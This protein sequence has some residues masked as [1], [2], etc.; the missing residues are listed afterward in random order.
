MKVGFVGLG[1]LG[2]E[3]AEVISEHYSLT[4]Y[5]INKNIKSNI[6]ISRT[7][8]ECC[9]D[10]N[11]V[12][13]A[14]PTP[15]H[16]NYDGRY[17]TSHLKPKDF[18][19]SIVKSVIKKIDKLIKQNTLIVL[20][21]TVLPGTIRREIFTLVKRGRFIYN[22]YLI[23]QGTVKY[24]LK[25]PEMIIIGTEKGELSPEALVLKKFYKKIIKNN[26]RYEIGNWEEAES[27]KVFYN[28]FITLKICFVNM[29]Q[30]VAQ[31]NKN[32]NV[33]I[34]TN[35]LKN[36][37]MRIMSPK[38]MNAG[39]GDGGGCHPRD[40]IALR[41]LSKKL[42][43]KYDLFSSLI[44]I[45]E[46][47]AENMANFLLGFQ[48]DIVILGKG[49]KPEV[50]QEDGSPSILVGYYAKKINKKINVYYDLNYPKNKKLTYL[51]YH[52]DKFKSLNFNK[53]SVIVDSNRKFKSTR[54]DLLVKYYGNPKK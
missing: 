25:N 34:V 47:Q 45:R 24:D 19:Y 12:F 41:W 15:H 8:K 30:D 4:G 51:L 44:F 10:K 33:D 43:I 14:V 26:I 52:Y 29:I 21:S 46:K 35:A 38:Y 13:L 23:A 48:N 11:I 31:N 3:V 54:K 42:R 5:D 28:T 1:K 37:N 2:M 39:L 27:I 7:L 20:I 22:P 53:N 49:F 18:D 6:K 16:K 17:P 36:S 32:I 50:D 9:F 40:N